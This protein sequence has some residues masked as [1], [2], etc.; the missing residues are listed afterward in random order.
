MIYQVTGISGHQW[1]CVHGCARVCAGV[2]EC[3]WVCVSVRE[4]AQ[5]CMGVCGYTWVCA[6]MHECALVCLGVRGE[7][8]WVC[9]G[10]RR[11]LWVCTGVHWCVRGYAWMI[12]GE[13]S[14]S[15]NQNISS[16][17]KMYARIMKNAVLK[18]IKICLVS[19]WLGKEVHPIHPGHTVHTNF[20]LLYFLI[21]T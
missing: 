10:V 8:V 2:R 7:Y 5:V 1:V 3:A 19:Q 11:C 6:G 4:C 16:K 17:T 15:Q 9:T 12:L 20:C 14:W 13:K 21:S 18:S